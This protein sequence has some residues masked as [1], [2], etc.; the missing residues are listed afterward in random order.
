MGAEVEVQNEIEASRQGLNAEIEG[1]VEAEAPRLGLKAE[2]EEAGWEEPSH[3]CSTGS[4]TISSAPSAC[5]S[6]H[7]QV[8]DIYCLMNLCR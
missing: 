1:E 5:C 8:L 3:I 7:L 2:A 6:V 4:E